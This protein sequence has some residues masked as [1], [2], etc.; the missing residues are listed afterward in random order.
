MLEDVDENAKPFNRY[1][2]EMNQMNVE[3][4]EPKID[5][6][7]KK[8]S[9]EKKDCDKEKDKKYHLMLKKEK[10]KS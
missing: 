10:V 7:K 9:L 4:S 8:G 6:K 1:D 2:K 5:K 3:S